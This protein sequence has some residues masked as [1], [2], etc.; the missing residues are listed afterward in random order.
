MKSSESGS[1]DCS[2]ATLTPLTLTP[3]VQTLRSQTDDVQRAHAELEAKY[4]AAQ[5]ERDALYSRFEE[6]VMAAQARA[7]A[8]NEIL[9][10]K[11][12]EAE[13]E[14]VT[15]KTQIEEVRRRRHVHGGSRAAASPPPAPPPLLHARRSWRRLAW[16]RP[17]WSPSASASTSCSRSAT[18]SSA[19]CRRPSACSPRRTT[20]PCVSSRH[21]CATWV[22]PSQSSPTR[23]WRRPREWAPLASSRNLPWCEPGPER[24]GAGALAPCSGFYCWLLEVFVSPS[25]R[26]K[27]AGTHWHTSS[28]GGGSI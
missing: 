19:T 5:A 2:T 26:H 1:I 7:E 10:R 28:H 3:L 21:A 8:R 17:R 23:C 4:A 6:L 27:Y 15:K 13:A 18:A 12:A 25:R 11:L 20:T 22:S 14:F 24:G 9:E 16:T